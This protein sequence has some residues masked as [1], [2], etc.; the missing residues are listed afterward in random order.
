MVEG[1]GEKAAVHEMSVSPVRCELAGILSGKF[2]E[3]QVAPHITWRLRRLFSAN[4]D[5]LPL[6]TR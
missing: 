3:W 5:Y 1:A 4:A 2:V 6:T